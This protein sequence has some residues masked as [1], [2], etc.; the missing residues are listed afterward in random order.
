MSTDLRPALDLALVVEIA[1]RAGIRCDLAEAGR[2]TVVRA[3]PNVGAA[4][5]TV[6]AGVR[7][8]PDGGRSWELFVGPPGSE[9]FRHVRDADERH[10][11]ALLVAQALASDPTRPLADDEISALGLGAVR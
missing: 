9:R 10:L 4:R 5:W 3:V 2:D 1:R 11:A 8:D 7:P 6:H